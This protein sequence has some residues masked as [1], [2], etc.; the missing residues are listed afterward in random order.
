MASTVVHLAFAGM[1]A[2]ALLGAAFDRRALLLVFAATA[3]PDLDSFL[4]LLSLGGHRAALHTLLLPLGLA[5]VLVVDT[6]GR[7]RSALRARW[8]ARGV[9]I[10]WVSIVCMAVAGIGLDLFTPG[11][12]NPLW[13]LHDQFYVIDGRLELSSRRGIVQTF[14]EWGNGGGPRPTALGSTEDVT[15][16]TGVDPG[17]GA[18]GDDGRVD[19]IFP[20]ARSGAQLLL[21]LVGTAVTIARF[22]VPYGL[23]PQAVGAEEAAES[24]E[25]RLEG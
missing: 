13:P 1:I 24:A 2:A 5:L 3:V 25:D 6:V 11:G 22:V 19:R 9:R 7:D 21:L 18:T 16:T 14:L 17:P 10:A 4:P 8:G 15:V 20:I 23:S 12:A